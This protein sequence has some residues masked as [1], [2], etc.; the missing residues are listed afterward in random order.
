MQK[1]MISQPIAD[2]SIGEIADAR[3][4]AIEKAFGMG[5]EVI[6]E[7]LSDK[8]Y[9]EM[10]SEGDTIICTPL[11]L[12]AKDLETMSKCN[13]VYFCKGWERMRGCRIEHEAAIAYGLNIIYES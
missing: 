5:Y 1:I 13:A 11:R 8:F 10:S 7:V 4:A 9:S 2:Q 12:L 6:D 3:S